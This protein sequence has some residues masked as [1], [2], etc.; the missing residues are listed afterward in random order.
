[1][2]LASAG[3]AVL[4]SHWGVAIARANLPRGLTRVD[5]IAIDARVMFVS[6]VAAVACCLLF[7][8][9]PAWLAVKGDLGTALKSGGSVIVGSRKRDRLLRVFLVSDTALAS[10]LLIATA[11]VVSSFLLVMATDLGFDRKDLMFLWFQQSL[12]GVEQSARPVTVAGLRTDLLD[13]VKAVPGVLHAA[14]VDGGTPLSGTRSGVRLVIPGYGETDSSQVDVLAVTADYFTTMGMQLLSG[15]S[16]QSSDGP[17]TALVAVVNDVFAR[18]FL[19]GSA[20]AGQVL[21]YKFPPPG[22]NDRHRRP[23]G[24]SVGWA[25]GGDQA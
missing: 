4:A 17:G 22:S 3:A 20:A 10:A 18:R 12:E 21:S 5:N 19:G 2:A 9:A 14:I 6:L 15:R 24:R 25:G 8:I 23:Q 16:F 11:L 13:H 1:M 7:S